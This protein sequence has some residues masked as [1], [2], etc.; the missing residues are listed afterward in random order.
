MVRVGTGDTDIDSRG[1]VFVAK[2]INDHMIFA[3]CLVV[4]VVKRHT[5]TV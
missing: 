1:Y 3:K 5:L 4:I 2:V